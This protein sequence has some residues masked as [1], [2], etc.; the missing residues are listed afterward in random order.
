MSILSKA[1]FVQI[2]SGYGEDKLYSEVPNTTNGDFQFTR[3]S[4]GTRVNS[5][6]YIEEV[7]YNLA[8]YSEDYSSGGWVATR[9]SVTTDDTTSPRGDTTADK[10]TTTASG[11][12]NRIRN[13]SFYQAPNTEHTFSAYAKK[14][15]VSWFLLRN[16]AFGDLLQGRVWFD[17]ENGVVGTINT[18]FTASIEDVG[19]GWF[20]CS[21]TCTTTSNPLQIVD[22]SPAPNDNDFQS[23]A[24]GEFCYV[25]GVQL[26]KGDTPKTYIKTTDRLNVPRLDYTNRDCPQILI[27][28]T[29]TNL[30]PY[31]EDFSQWS[32]NN[33]INIDQAIS[34]S[35][36]TEADEMVEALTN[37]YQYSYIFTSGLSLNYRYVLSCFV[38]D[39]DQQ[40][41][42]LSVYNGGTYLS[43][44]FDLTNESFTTAENGGQYTYRNAT[45]E[46]YANDWY[47]VSL[48]FESTT[49]TAPIIALCNN[50]S[51]TAGYIPLYTGTGKKVLVWG[52]QLE[53]KDGNSG[54]KP[55]SY[56]PTN[57]TSVTRNYD[58]FKSGDLTSV[59]NTSQ[60]VFYLDFLHYD[61]IIYGEFFVRPTD[62]STTNAINFRTQNINNPDRNITQFS[63][64]ASGTSYGNYQWNDAY[65]N[66]G[67]KYAFA[68]DGNVIKHYINGVKKSE[69][70][71]TFSFNA[72]FGEI[73]MSRYNTPNQYLGF[74]NPLRQVAYFNEMLTDEELETLTT[75]IATSF[76]ALA[77][78]WAYELL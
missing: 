52:A 26:V 36:L 34:P 50:N 28:K 73:K 37:T 31:S 27:E 71:A 70:T 47:R 58:Y 42:Q 8:S 39:I 35:G 22:F 14:G 74:H 24:V 62:N 12:E 75:P 65:I 30:V 63:L 6:G 19:D 7:P 32:N 44:N 25:W 48:E 20:R 56:I 4:T 2:P 38:K 43:A 54:Y 46:Q 68:W 41:F 55:T 61:N 45:I 40:Y 76:Q 18:G 16:I 9:L 67:V 77:E 5:D 11:S 51:A 66:M 72:D 60:G 78:Y 10:I 59:L 3:A 53:R 64:T 21:M 17:L 69:T 1:S 13:S 29:A 33:I 23:D 49:T 57:G 15:N